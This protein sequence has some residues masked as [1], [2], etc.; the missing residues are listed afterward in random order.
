MNNNCKISCLVS[1]I[2]LGASIYTTLKCSECPP[3]KEYQDSLNEEQKNIYKNIVE[4]R[5]KIYIKGMIFGILLGLGYIYYFKGSMDII[6]HSCIFTA[7]ALFTQYLTYNL[8]KKATYMVRHLE[9]SD[10]AKKYNDVYVETKYRYHFGMVL[11]IIG[12][13][14]LSN[15]LLRL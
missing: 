2:F 14:L 7:I 11:G 3:F 1:A 12:Y 6:K 10:Q 4:E 5:K 8:H 13:F 9:N 15:G